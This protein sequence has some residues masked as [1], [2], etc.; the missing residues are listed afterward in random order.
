MFV[1]RINAAICSKQWNVLRNLLDEPSASIPAYYTDLA[2]RYGIRAR[3]LAM[4]VD[5]SIQYQSG[6]TLYSG[7]QINKLSHIKPLVPVLQKHSLIPT[8]PPAPAA[9]PV[10]AIISPALAPV[11]TTDITSTN[12]Q[13]SSTLTE[14]ELEVYVD[15]YV[16]ETDTGKQKQA[17]LNMHLLIE[18]TIN[19]TSSTFLK[20]VASV[21][22]DAF[23]KDL[24]SVNAKR[25]W[26]ALFYASKKNNDFDNESPYDRQSSIR[27]QTVF[28]MDTSKDKLFNGSMDITF[29]SMMLKSSGVA[30][31]SNRT[32]AKK[33]TKKKKKKKTR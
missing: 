2:Q 32:T 29:R 15:R 3:D 5:K 31:S 27:L 1:N 28:D 22:K 21:L 4:L 6:P 18:N 10:P 23:N 11:T 24:D 20:T 12:F 8:P 33:L 19:T 16:T 25:A 13:L 17:L 9:P 14:P 7:T 30:P 26:L